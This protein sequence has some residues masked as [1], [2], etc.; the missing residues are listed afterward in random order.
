M[1]E[2]RD[3]L[4]T[5]D[6]RIRELEGSQEQL[7]KTFDSLRQHIEDNLTTLGVSQDEQRDK[8]CLLEGLLG[9][10]LIEDEP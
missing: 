8:L 3:S 5:K 4:R 1:F 7:I 6:S 2:I 9:K 10:R